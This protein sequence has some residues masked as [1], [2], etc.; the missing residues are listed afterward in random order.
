[1]YVKNLDPVVTEKHL[2]EKFS[3]FGKIVSLAIKKDENGQSKGFG[4]VNYDSPDD[5]RRAMEA[6]D[7]SQFGNL[8]NFL[9]YRYFLHKI[10][11]SWMLILCLNLVLICHK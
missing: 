2:E 8:F 1:L 3:S 5:A 9:V 11:L 4:F 10:A 6:M 7:G